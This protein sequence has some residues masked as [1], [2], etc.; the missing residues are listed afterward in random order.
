MKILRKIIGILSING[1]Q[2]NIGDVSIIRIC[3]YRVGSSY[4]IAHALQWVHLKA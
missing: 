3:I 2:Q 4:E 1:D